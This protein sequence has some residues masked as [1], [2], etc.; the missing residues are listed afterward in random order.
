MVNPTRGDGP[1]PM[2][3]IPGSSDNDGAQG[4]AAANLGDHTVSRFPSNSGKK[5]LSDRISSFFR[6]V[7]GRGASSSRRSSSSSSASVSISPAA[8]SPS[9]QQVSNA[10]GGRVK[11]PAPQPPSDIVSRL[12][13]EM[14]AHAAG[15]PTSGPATASQRLQAQWTNYEDTDPLGYQIHGVEVLM[16]SLE[17][18]LQEQIFLSSTGTPLPSEFDDVRKDV[19]DL[20]GYA[21]RNIEMPSVVVSS[22]SALFKVFLSLV[23]EGP[24]LQPG[25]SL[26]DFVKGR[27]DDFNITDQPD[28]LRGRMPRML[29]LAST[30]DNLRAQ[31]PKEMPNLWAPMTRQVMATLNRYGNDLRSQSS[32]KYDTAR[33][34]EEVTT[35]MRDLK[36]M[37]QVNHSAYIN[38]L[39]ILTNDVI[40]SKHE[41]GF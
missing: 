4:A 29:E 16:K 31:Y 30:L 20:L 34:K 39:N 25:V 1:G 11:R 8:G 40:R 15:R 2:G 6:G 17:S 22:D 14:A 35:S 10:V 27:A 37:N 5:S 32:G 19:I 38:A 24:H 36:E 12:T 18:S 33:M 41:E 13:R 3:G 23:L 21:S 28:P 7:F 9:S 26:V